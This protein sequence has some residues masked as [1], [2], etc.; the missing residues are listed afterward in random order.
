MLSFHLLKAQN[1]HSSMEATQKTWS[2]RLSLWFLSIPFSYLI[3]HAFVDIYFLYSFCWHRNPRL[4]KCKFHG[5]I[6]LNIKFV[7][8][9]FAFGIITSFN[10]LKFLWIVGRNMWQEIK[11]KK[12]FPLKVQKMA[13]RTGKKRLEL[14]LFANFFLGKNC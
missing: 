6:Y 14:E 9:P 2:S 8:S 4:K 5:T 1:F 10:W 12:T 11:A 3:H 7:P 13:N